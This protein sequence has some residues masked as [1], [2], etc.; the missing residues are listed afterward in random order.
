MQCDKENREI[1][2]ATVAH[3]KQEKAGDI[4]LAERAWNA[5]H[6]FEAS[7]KKGGSSCLQL[8]FS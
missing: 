4:E 6:V 5:F 7:K 1:P 3:L 2:S 8:K